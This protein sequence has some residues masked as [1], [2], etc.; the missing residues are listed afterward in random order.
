VVISMHVFQVTDVV[1]NEPNSDTKQRPVAALGLAWANMVTT[2]LQLSRTAHT[3]PD[4]HQSTLAVSVRT[5]EVVFAPH[6]PNNS[7]HFIVT[8]AGVSGIS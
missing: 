5:L 8:R 4:P 7:C 6:L 2:R 3:V 1:C